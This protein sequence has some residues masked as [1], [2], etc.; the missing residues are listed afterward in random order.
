VVHPYHEFVPPYS[1]RSL[2]AL[3]L[4]RIG[5]REIGARVK[6]WVGRSIIVLSLG[7][8]AFVGS[9]GLTIVFALMFGGM[10]LG[11]SLSYLLR[12]LR[13]EGP[14]D[15]RFHL[16]VTRHHG[17][18]EIDVIPEGGSEPAASCVLEDAEW[19][20]PARFWRR[21]TPCF[22]PKLLTL[23]T[24]AYR[25]EH[26]QS[27]VSRLEGAERGRALGLACL[28]HLARRLT[29]LGWRVAKAAPVIPL[30]PIVVVAAGFLL[31]VFVFHGAKADSG[32]IIKYVLTHLQLGIC[33]L[34]AWIAFAPWLRAVRIRKGERSLD[35][36]DAME[37]GVYRIE[38]TGRPPVSIDHGELLDEDLGL[39]RP[40][41]L[42]E[43]IYELLEETASTADIGA[44]SA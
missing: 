35:F 2:L 29:E 34:F 8:L 40:E 28:G 27:L 33:V 11:G 25:R 20:L 1:F 44:P 24:A 12:G 23:V 42:D 16:A 7:W 26:G 19:S 13:F 10:F 38:R 9:L 32:Y 18:A 6:V 31:T 22:L 43:S 14:G 36:T 15:F 3:Q 41:L 4:S 30:P 5:C 21:A 17:R 37:Q 39:R